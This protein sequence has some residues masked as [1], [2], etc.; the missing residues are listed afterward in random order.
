MGKKKAIAIIIVLMSLFLS[1]CAGNIHM[2][3]EGN[4]YREK[5]VKVY[6]AI[7]MDKNTRD[8]KITLRFYEDQPNVAYVSIR[9]Y[10]ATVMKDSKECEDPQMK[11]E[12]QSDGTYFL[13]S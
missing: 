10:Y 3:A 6:R 11:V 12:K 8:G 2:D 13:T 4:E 9:D 7:R 1:A 5:S